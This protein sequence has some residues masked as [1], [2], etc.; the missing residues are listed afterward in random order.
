MSQEPS[1]TSTLSEAQ[2]SDLI[3]L[4][5]GARR[6]ALERALASGLPI[7]A[8]FLVP[9]AGATPV[10]LRADL[11]ADEIGSL[12][13]LP[14]GSSVR[15]WRAGKRVAAY[16]RGTGGARDKRGSGSGRRRGELRLER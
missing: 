10:V 12:V 7:D 5:A 15:S 1:S 6:A 4:S 8:S 11:T 16:R 3:A 2:L 13:L 14:R 9:G